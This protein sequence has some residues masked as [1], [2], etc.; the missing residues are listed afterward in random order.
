MERVRRIVGS[1]DVRLRKSQEDPYA[2]EPNVKSDR[3]DPAMASENL[4]KR[5]K[6]DRRANAP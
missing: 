2:A 4:G 6:P 1:K 5:S 3:W